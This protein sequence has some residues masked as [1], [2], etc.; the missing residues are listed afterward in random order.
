[1]GLYLI[2]KNKQQKQLIIYQAK[3]GEIEFRGDFDRETIWGSINQIADVFGVQK[4]AIS[5]H[6]KNIYKEKELGKK[7][8]CFHFG[9]SSN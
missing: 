2:M 9:N 1:M 5:K 7:N 8:N 4:A 6:L 3:S